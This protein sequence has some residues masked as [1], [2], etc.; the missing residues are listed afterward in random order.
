MKRSTWIVL[1]LF[2]LAIGAYFLI[3]NRQAK[4]AGLTPTATASSFL[5]G[6]SDGTL[7][8]IRINDKQGHIVQVQRETG[9]TWIVGLPVAG[10][11]D[12][13]LAGAAETQ[14]GALRIV[15]TL[16]PQ[17]VLKDVG[18]DTPSDTI[19][20]GYSTSITHILEVG[21]LTP[22]SSGYY[23][24]LDGGKIQVISQSG[25]ESLL[26]LLTAPPYMA[27][28]TPGPTTEPTVTSTP[29]AVTPTAE[30]STPSP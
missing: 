29:E 16:D 6:A 17:P 8:S 28:E 26:N 25:I 10:P 5:F 14:V 11:A 24:R 13:G 19:T 21:N 18:L 2:I 7:V 20:L 30:S 3:E 23:V 22:T 15:A 1:I 9:G 12:Q 4:Q 27:T